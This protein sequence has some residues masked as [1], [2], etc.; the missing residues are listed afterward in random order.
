MWHPLKYVNMAKSLMSVQNSVDSHAVN[1]L[2][3]RNN[4]YCTKKLRIKL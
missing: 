3:C 1:L 4:I 2:F